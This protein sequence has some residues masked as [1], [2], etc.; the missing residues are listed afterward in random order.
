VSE[1]AELGIDGV[2][3]FTLSAHEDSR[4]Q[5]SEVFRQEWLPG[6]PPI[7]QANLSIS[8]A[9]VLRGL[10][11]HRRQSDYWCVLAG[12]AFVGLFDLRSGSPTEAARAEVRLSAELGRSGLYIP[13]GVAHGFLAET[14]LML[15]Y[16]VDRPFDGQDE[17][18]VAWND[19]GIA[20]AWP[21]G[22]PELSDRD[23]TNPP[24]AEVRAQAEAQPQ[25]YEP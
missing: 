7:V 14:E 5:V 15:A 17:F 23:R 9:G 16:F 1:S 21:T 20:I 8:R 22:Q 11:F 19:P 12:T 25:P 13:P 18:G 4:G 3:Q 10:H 24:L 6:V 2:R